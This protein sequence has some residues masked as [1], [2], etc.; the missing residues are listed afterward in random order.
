MLRI[1]GIDSDNVIRTMIK[2]SDNHIQTN[3]R[4]NYEFAS[5]LAREY[6]CVVFYETESKTRLKCVSLRFFLN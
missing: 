6:K 1:Q 2:H 3:F 4:E 5:E